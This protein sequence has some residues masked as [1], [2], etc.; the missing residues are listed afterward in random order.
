LE[1]TREQREE[2]RQLVAEV[3]GSQSIPPELEADLKAIRRLVPAGDAFETFVSDDEFIGALS[4]TLVGRSGYSELQGL[5]KSSSRFAEK[6]Q[7]T[8]L[9]RQLKSDSFADADIQEFADE[10][11]EVTSAAGMTRQTAM[12]LLQIARGYDDGTKLYVGMKDKTHFEVTDS[13]FQLFM[14]GIKP[15]SLVTLYATGPRSHAILLDAS[16]EFIQQPRRFDAAKMTS[17]TH[18]EKFGASP[19][20][21]NEEVAVG[22]NSDAP[23][24]E[25]EKE[26][27]V[28]RGHSRRRRSSRRSDRGYTPSVLITSGRGV[29][30]P[31]NLTNLTRGIQR[32]GG[33]VVRPLAR[34]RG[35]K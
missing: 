26:V 16:T 27:G 17:L 11:R 23:A 4:R 12:R 1:I 10:S 8:H 22:S 31:A 30:N 5:L 21:N 19:Q 13:I 7:P 9:D 15:N 33:V 14:T 18:P 2:A 28:G 34:P 35:P 25:D 6:A 20:T 32:P 29:A 3:R 24:R